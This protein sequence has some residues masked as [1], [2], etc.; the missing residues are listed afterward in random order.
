MGAGG[1]KLTSYTSLQ[2]ANQVSFI[3]PEY[4]EFGS[5]IIRNG[6]SGKDLKDIPSVS[7]AMDLLFGHKHHTKRMTLVTMWNKA[8][9][10]ELRYPMLYDDGSD[11]GS[12]E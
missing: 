4:E 5:K 7:E 8:M 10:H 6:I 11:D 12:T 3:G 1:T 9:D 2:L